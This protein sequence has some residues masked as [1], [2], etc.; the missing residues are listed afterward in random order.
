MN[1][2]LNAVNVED[3]IARLKS[4]NLDKTT[5]NKTAELAAKL[6]VYGLKDVCIYG[7]PGPDGTCSKFHVMKDDASLFLDEFI[8]QN[9]SL[10][11]I[12]IFPIG[13]KA[14]E[15]YEVNVRLGAR[16]IR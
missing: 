11:D 1:D 9:S 13:I 15:F 14:P 6:S 16:K 12:E 5:L 4:G 2:E 3:V 10:I 8:K 7:Q